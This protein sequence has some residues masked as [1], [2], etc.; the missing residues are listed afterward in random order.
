MPSIKLFNIEQ[1][2]ILVEESF[3]PYHGRCLILQ[4]LDIC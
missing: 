2:T 4:T 1:G 3:L